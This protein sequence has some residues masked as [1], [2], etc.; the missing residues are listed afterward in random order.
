MRKGEISKIRMKKIHGFGRPLKID[1]LKFPVD[2]SEE[3]SDGRKRLVGE[4]IIYEVE[5][6]DFIERQDIEANGIFYKLFSEKCHKNEWETP[7]DRDEIKYS[8]T[9]R[10]GDS[11]FFKEENVTTDLKDKKFTVTM[12]KVLTSMKRGEKCSVEINKD[13]V[14][15]QDILLE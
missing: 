10:Q 5:L 2:Y 11:V 1:E 13:F 3:G 4:T 6:I 8:L 12:H 7:S 14:P 15:Q 9:I